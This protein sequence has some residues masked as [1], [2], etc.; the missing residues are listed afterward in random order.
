M[1]TFDFIASDQ[2]RVSLERDFEELIACMK[3]GAWKAAHV[4]AGSLIQA[5]LAD[6]VV[7]TARTTE[8]EA[9]RLPL[10]DLLEICRA[11]GVLSQRTVELSGFI[12]PYADFLSPSGRLRLRAAIDETSARIAQALLEIV[13]TEVSSH[14]QDHYRHSAE[15]IATKLLSDPSSAAILAHLLGKIS[16]AELERLLTRVVPKALFEAAKSA[17]PGAS[18]T[19]DRLE[20]CYRMGFELAPADL[21]RTVAKRFIEVLEN[22]SE[23]VVQA[24]QTRFFRGSDLAFLDQQERSIVKA[25]LFATLEKNVPLALVRAAEGIGAFLTT[26]S[27]TRAFFVPLVLSLLEARDESYMQACFRRVVEESR[28]LTDEQRRNLL[29]WVGRL[30]WSLQ[31]DDRTGA[32]EAI[33]RLESLLAAPPS[34]A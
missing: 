11:E 34:A 25:H 20:R 22:E 13:I 24:H 2:L 26:E 28:L 10:S 31:K 8:E 12:R 30:R 9:L 32:A 6:H 7:S 21:K 16:R 33:A 1:A 19:L 5:T 23:F 3:A 4:I 18:E 14:K 29:G 17:E 15:H 27:E